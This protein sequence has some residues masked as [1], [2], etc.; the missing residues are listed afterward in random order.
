M[1]EVGQII[2]LKDTDVLGVITHT[3]SDWCFSVWEAP[4]GQPYSVLKNTISTT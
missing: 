2:R 3:K 1:F 4:F